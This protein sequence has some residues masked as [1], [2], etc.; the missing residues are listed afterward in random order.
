[1]KYKMV[2]IDMDGTLLGKDRKISEKNKEV[3]KR[4]H[5]KGVEIVVTTGRIYN[6]AAY[7]SHIL[8]VKSPVIAANGAIVREKENDKIIY[9]GYIPK[10][11]C[12]EIIEVLNKY[13]IT[14]Q[15]YTTDTI[16]VSNILSKI[17]TELFMT[18]QI[19]YEMLKIKYV[20]VKKNGDWK[21]I[22]ETDNCKITKCIAFSPNIKKINAVN[23]ELIKMNN[24]TICG[25]GKRSIEINYKNISKGNAVRALGE[26]YGISKNEIMC[27]GDNENDI[28]MI[29]YAGLGVA[30]GNAIGE[31]KL[32]A[33]YVTDTNNEDGV[34]KAIEKFIINESN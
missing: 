15:L 5:K 14:F 20:L 27:I 8:G 12:L 2:C 30:M 29:K 26:Y 24:I 3:I 32:V 17:G 18:K 25:S 11:D 22:L 1:M 4:A 9:E 31:L 16:Y 10:L 21:K 28:S 23:S 6:N 34:A 33:D 19:G 13:K 7:F